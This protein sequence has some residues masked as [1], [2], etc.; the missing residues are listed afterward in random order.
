[1]RAGFSLLRRR[2]SRARER[3]PS[4]AADVIA[5]QYSCASI[6]RQASGYFLDARKDGHVE[7]D[8]FH[9]MESLSWALVRVAVVAG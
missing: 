6:A 7:S 8:R 5:V 2:I 1:M 9:F 3:W 4:R